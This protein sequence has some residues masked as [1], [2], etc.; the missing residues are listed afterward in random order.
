M[1][2]MSSG[3]KLKPSRAMK[4]GTS[5]TKKHRFVSFSQRIARL[6]IDPIHK[7]RHTDRSLDEDDPTASYFK[8]DLDK[9]KDLNLSENF[10]SFLREVS[11]LCNTLP[12]VLHYQGDIARILA[13]YIKKGDSL[14]LEPLLSLL[15]CFAH[16]LGS[17]FETYFSDAVALVTSLAAK[18][19]DVEVIEWSF[20][21]LAWLFKYLSRLLVP[22]LRPLLQ[23]MSPLL[24]KES[25]KIFITRFAAESLSFLI[26]K[27]ALV[28][29]KSQQPLQ[30]AVSFILEDL[31][32]LGWEGNNVPIYYYGLTTL[33]VDAIKGIDRRLHSSGPTLCGSLLDNIIHGT[34]EVKGRMRLLEGV[35]VGLIHHTEASTFQPV[36][37]QCLRSIQNEVKQERNTQISTPALQICERLLCVLSTV[38]KGS[39]VLEWVPMLDALLAL[40]KVREDL[41]GKPTQALYETTVVIMQSAPLDVLIPRIRPIMDRIANSQNQDYFLVFCTFFCQLDKER[42]ESL[43]HPYLVK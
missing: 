7:T 9:W 23:I 13:T 16:D 5:S 35:T 11:P 27:A 3:K 4:S 33:L 12:Q 15:A 6:N 25:Q 22:D 30:N 38:R 17:K 28:Y 2:A 32:L 8:A 40:L 34:G 26:R 10:T 20:N 36:L 19:A 14:S 29:H 1:A 39:R 24:G 18:H 21:C 43:I 31:D 41:D 37:E 42:F